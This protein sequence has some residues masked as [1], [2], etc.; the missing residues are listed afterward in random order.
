MSSDEDS[1][2]MINRPLDEDPFANDQNPRYHWGR[3]RRKTSL[4]LSKILTLMN[5]SS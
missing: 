2:Q 4:G 3:G 1:A 5:F